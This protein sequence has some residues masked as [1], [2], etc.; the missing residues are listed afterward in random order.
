[1]A[2][3]I[4]QT[5]E[6]LFQTVCELAPEER[7]AYLDR[8]CADND[9][10]RREIEEL[11][12]YYESSETFLE[13]PAL[14]DAARH[15]ANQIQ[16]S[17]DQ[18]Q[19]EADTLREG[20]WMLGP[21]RILDQLGKGGM[22]VVY[23]A[24][25]TR[26]QKQVAIK[27]LPKDIDWDEDRLARFS[28]EGRML[29]ELKHLK[30]PNIAEIYEQTEYDGKPCIVLEYVPGETLSERLRNSPL[31]ISEAL[32]YALQIA[33]ALKSAHD[34]RIVHR[35][36]KPANIKITP[37]G[38][39]KVLD[40]GLAKRFQ[41][42]LSDEERSDLRTR[43]LSLTESGM[44]I[45]TPA[46]MSPEQW[47]GKL[48][49]QR[50]DIWA[51][52]CLLFEMIAGR[53]PFTGKTRVETMKAVCN[54]TVNWGTLPS[55]TPLI[56][57][58]LLRRCLNR[59]LNSRLQE[60]V[61]A[62]QLVIEALG[63]TSRA[64]MLFFK[65]LLW[66]IERKTAITMA[67]TALV[68]I[69]VLAWRYTPLEDRVREFMGAGFIIK[70]ND[71]LT[72]ILSER[73]QGADAELL[74]AALMPDQQSAI[75]LLEQSDELRENEDYLEVIDEII[76]ALN[77]DFKKEKVSAQRY[78]ILA[79]AH[80]FKFYLLA[81]HEDKDAAVTA[82]QK[83]QSL[84]P[85]TFEV[86]LVLGDL[87]NAIGSADQAIPIFEK[88]LSNPQ[89]PND[90]RALLGQAIAYDLKGNDERVEQLYKL[91]IAECEKRS[92]GRK[93]WPYYNELGAFYFSQGEYD[94]AEKNW[95][96]VVE[97]NNLNPSGYSNLGNIL[98]YQGCIDEATSLYTQ[99]INIKATVD[100]YSNRGTVYFF[101]GK[102][103]EAIRDFEEVTVSRRDLPGESDSP[104]L[105][106]NL[107]DAYRIVDRRDPAIQ[108]YRKALELA[109]ARLSN[110]PN[111][112]AIKA[113]KAEWIAKLYS[114]GVRESQQDP[115]TM[116]AEVLKTEDQ[117]PKYLGIAVIVYYL[118]GERDKAVSTSRQAVEAGY[119]P[120]LLKQNPEIAGLRQEREFQ[121]IIQGLKPKC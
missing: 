4:R 77:E 70:E 65:S 62:K 91:S 48:I 82:C 59:D 114:M 71:D 18:P 2:S 32:Q 55:E 68:L 73:V 106:G 79:Q 6:D 43:S 112:P 40:F 66:K 35:D 19:A 92:G 17:E 38:R 97:L 85:E 28:R 50:T 26:D 52:G 49:D 16:D 10:L 57:L 104:E 103:Q 116:I 23:L 72:T 30:H 115:A 89:N 14:E 41:V 31:P 5:V 93:C 46:Y 61:E 69:I 118:S 54:S 110:S 100:G 86:L 27:V 83:A 37:E 36:L 29:E 120:Y 105:W 98:L 1:M 44:L 60:A 9:A 108:S 51:F 3:E 109:E 113:L 12:K 102:Y 7:T 111:D 11:L 47:E 20:D 64:P 58:D 67:A 15:L 21:Y 56:V 24:E 107:G 74:R 22:G 90:P 101:Q 45:G 84:N 76:K 99:S 80:L 88:A 119:S 96:K 13:K 78:A 95:R 81:K 121:Q 87:F 39:V 94:Q 53:P 8:A 63:G 75:D 25:D 33:D 42:E 117:V 34:Q